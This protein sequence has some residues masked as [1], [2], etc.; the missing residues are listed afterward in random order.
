MDEVRSAGAGVLLADVSRLCVRGGTDTSG[1]IAGVEIVGAFERNGLR[2]MRADKEDGGRDRCR[3]L[4]VL[5][6]SLKCN[7][8]ET[9]VVGYMFVVLSG[10]AP[11]KLP[12]AGSVVDVREGFA[13]EF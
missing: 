11:F 6:G 2:R 10:C 5:I 3:V 7:A 4:I 1:L 8:F 9:G 13:S 12:A